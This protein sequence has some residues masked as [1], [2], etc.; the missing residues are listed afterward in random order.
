MDTWWSSGENNLKYD[1]TVKI[2]TLMFL[3]IQKTKKNYLHY[4]HMKKSLLL[5]KYSDAQTK[6]NMI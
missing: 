2:C 5:K 3:L 1:N 6:T 4:I